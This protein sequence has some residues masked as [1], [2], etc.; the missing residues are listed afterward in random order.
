MVRAPSLRDSRP[1]SSGIFSSSAGKYMRW[2]T[3]A[4]VT[5]SASTTSF[6]GSFMCS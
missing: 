2:R 5:V 6:S 4:A 3:R 1:S